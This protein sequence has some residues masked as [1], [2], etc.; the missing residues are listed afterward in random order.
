MRD[1]SSVSPQFWIG[2]TGKALRG[3]MPAQILALYLMTSPHANMIGVFYCPIDYMAKETGMTLEGASEALQ[4]LIDADFC[5]FDHATEEV[6]VVRMAAFQVGDELDAKD[7]RCKGVARELE[8]VTSSQLQQGFRANY[9]VPFNLPIPSIQTPKTDRPSEAPLKPLRSQEQ[10]QEQEQEQDQKK[11]AVAPAIPGV[12]DSLMADFLKIRKAK[13]APLTETAITGIQR[14]ADK[15]GLSMAEA[16]TACCEYSWQGFNA[17]WYAE[18]QSKPGK[19]A[20]PAWRK[21]ARKR[22]QE[23][24]PSIAEKSGPPAHEFFEL[25]AKNVTPAA[26][27]R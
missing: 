12:P 15:A 13:K 17:E 23:A 20:E 16:I 21:D 5:R 9:A 26:L 6:F 25:E 3:N 8:K 24:V 4:S 1:Y 2:Q 27:G 11:S 19:S 18:R 7:N 22:M 14:E 10:E